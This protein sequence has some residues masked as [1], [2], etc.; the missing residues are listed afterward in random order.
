MLNRADHDSSKPVLTDPVCGMQVAADSERRYVYEGTEYLF[1]CDSCRDKFAAAPEKYL[2][3]EEHGS[4]A[5]TTAAGHCLTG[6]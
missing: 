5:E 1:C 4:T 3:P 2:H 6:T